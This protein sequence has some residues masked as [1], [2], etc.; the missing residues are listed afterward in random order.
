MAVGVKQAVYGKLSVGETS[1]A[2]NRPST[3]ERVSV[4]ETTAI[5]S[6]L[7]ANPYG[8]QNSVSRKYGVSRL[9]QSADSSLKLRS[10]RHASV[11]RD[12]IIRRVSGNF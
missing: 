7:S 6:R 1:A 3:A 9:T 11:P 8:Q 10:Q 2:W 4:G 5:P 12:F